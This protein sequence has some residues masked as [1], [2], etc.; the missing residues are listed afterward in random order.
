MGT[1]LAGGVSRRGLKKAGLEI[2]LIWPPFSDVPTS[3]TIE[4][5]HVLNDEILPEVNAS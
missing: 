5:S 2:P 3:K 4:D 1:P